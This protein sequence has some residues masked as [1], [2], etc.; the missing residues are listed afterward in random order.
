MEIR[1]TKNCL[2]RQKA[3]Q[4]FIAKYPNYCKTCGGTG[5]WY[6]YATYW[7]DADGGPCSCVE[8][9][10]CP[11]CGEK[12]LLVDKEGLSDCLKCNWSERYFLFDAK[13]V[14]PDIACPNTECY[15][16]EGLDEEY[17]KEIEK[18]IY[19]N[20]SED[21]DD[22][23]SLEL[24]LYH[25]ITDNDDHWYVIEDGEEEF[26]HEWVEDME[27]DK[28]SEYDFEGCRINGSPSLVYFKEWFE[29]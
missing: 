25:L 15:C 29:K 20:D 26:F 17:N 13:N 24:V 16:G 14:P 27:N 8:E 11:R 28:E 9:G 18:V 12:T 21:N 5:Y 1:H 3:Y 4:N 22:E 2:E 10:I 23:D 19:E 7:E 6:T